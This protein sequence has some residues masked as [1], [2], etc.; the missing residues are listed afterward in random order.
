MMAYYCFVNRG[1][2]PGQYNALSFRERAI[3]AE[4]VKL[5]ISKREEAIKK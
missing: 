1:W 5:E 3:V 4:F 2:T